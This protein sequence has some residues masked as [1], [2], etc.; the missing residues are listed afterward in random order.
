MH[1]I[2]LSS[3]TLCVSWWVSWRVYVLNTYIMKLIWLG[4][5]VALL[6]SMYL[7]VCVY[8]LYG[9]VYVGMCL[10]VLIKDSIV[11]VCFVLCCLFVVCMCLWVCI[12]CCVVVLEFAACIACLLLT[13]NTKSHKNCS[14]WIKM[15][16]I[17]Y[18]CLLVDWGFDIVWDSTGNPGEYHK[19]APAKKVSDWRELGSCP[20]GG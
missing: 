11:C 15:W 5:S 19:K 4:P 6:V 20:T 8:V 13:W 2:V 12:A 9:W 16:K 7:F 18:C 10:C 17:K 1:H 3:K 14:D